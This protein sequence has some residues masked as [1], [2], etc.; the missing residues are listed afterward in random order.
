M[1]RHK[2]IYSWPSSALKGLI[3]ALILLVLSVHAEAKPSHGI[4]MHGAPKYPAAF[5]QFD[6]VNPDA[7]KGGAIVFGVLGSFD[8]LNPLIVRGVSAAGVRDY[9]FES[10]MGR[11][12]DEPFSLY[13]LLAK[14]IET[15]ADRSSVSFWLRP[16]ARFSDGR[17]VSVD[18]VIFS[19]KLLR[20]HGRPN[21]RT[22]YAKVSKVER[23]GERG[24]KFSFDADGDREMPLI[25]GLMPILPAHHYTAASFEKTSLT[26]PLGSGPYTVGEIKPGASVSYVRNPDYWGW[27]LSLNRG[28]FNFDRVRYDYFRDASAL[29]EAFKKGLIH[30]R[31]EGDPGR[32]SETYNFPA[33]SDG[34]V[35]KEEFPIRTPSGMS[36]LVFN[37]RRDIF[38]DATVRRALSIMFDFEWLNRS[39]YHGLY[40]R[41]Q[42]YFDRSELSSHGRPADAR[43]RE[44][45]GPFAEQIGADILEG[46]HSLPV[47][48]GSGRKPGEPPQGARIAKRSRI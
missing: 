5:P 11:A 30:V 43:E 2:S 15:P 38:A 7:P 39:L 42:S 37:S 48:D 44:L 47:S 31:S 45:L 46:R 19:H 6:Y 27:G 13:G 25:M 9:V 12:M 34:R 14:A 16:E 33:I 22:Y 8:S 23:L 35:L 24:V 21:H 36:A 18:D 17:Q 20:D 4:A 1:L 28:R 3:C 40:S 32:W 10:L 41:T 29:F 26:A